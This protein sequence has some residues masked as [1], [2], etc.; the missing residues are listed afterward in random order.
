M[1][2]W[3]PFLLLLSFPV[4]QGF[5]GSL[6]QGLVAHWA[7]DERRGFY[8]TD[9]ISG[10][11]SKINYVFEK[12]R[13]KPSSD[14]RWFDKGVKGGALLFD[15]YSTWIEVEPNDFPQIFGSFSVEVW[16]APKV[17]GYGD[18]GKLSAIISQS[19]EHEKQGFVLGTFRHGS[20]GF[21]LGTGKEWITLIVYDPPLKKFAWNYIVATVDVENHALKL[22]LN[23]KKVKFSKI[24][25]GSKMIQA[26]KKALI[27]RNSDSLTLAGFPLNMFC[28]I[29]DELRIYNRA[30][31][32]E[33]VIRQYEFYTKESCIPKLSWYDFI[34]ENLYA[35]DLHRPTYHAIPPEHWM[36]EP[37]APFYYKGKY[38][39]FY[40]HNPQ[41][42]YWHNIHWGHWVSDDMVHWVHLPYALTPER[43][44][45][46]PDGCWS[47][48]VTFNKDGIPVIFYTAGNDR[49][50]PNQRIAMARPNDPED[51]YLVSWVKHPEPVLVQKPGEGL[52]GEFRDPF[53]WKDDSEEKWYMLVGSG[54][55]TEHAGAALIYTSKDLM[56]WQY[57]GVLYSQ[58]HRA[59][60][61][62]WELPVLLP[63]KDTSGKHRKWI[64]LVSPARGG[65]VEVWYWLGKFDKE[66]LRFVP[67]HTEPRLLDV[68][69]GV[70][71][72][73]SGFVD[74]QSGRTILFTIAQDQRSSYQ[75]YD[76]GWAHN[77]GLP[78][79]LYL[80]D[81]NTVGLKPIDELH[82]LRE[83][84]LLNARNLTIEQANKLIL[85]NQVRGATLEI[86]AEFNLKDN[87]GI[88]VKVMTSKEEY[89]EETLIYYDKKEHS[90]KVDREFSSYDMFAPSF[91]IQGG[92]LELKSEDLILHIYVDHSLIE[93]YANGKISLTTRTYPVDSESNWIRLWSNKKETKV[94]QIQV[95]KLR[96]ATQIA[97]EEK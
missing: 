38:H 72:G 57:G 78:V 93:T 87:E 29:M 5:T 94:K 63:I 30:I 10:E 62:V 24:P 45:L 14:P 15:G 19:N 12:A 7:F 82:S 35:G 91:G 52:W 67:D 73:P 28:G 71:T 79:E 85:D 21:T 74:P 27:G 36:N 61:R 37:H 11:V 68:G 32:E 81:E 70:F 76:A 16:I 43:G 25:H 31:T 96:S 9:V 20:W 49:M 46:D 95:W 69:N 33:E 55:P 41:G 64:L 17:F 77:A 89:G 6:D 1:K 4:A 84:I 75:H 90:L 58:K 65:D 80:I 50:N 42:P 83:N 66:N 13:Y 59:L 22:Y 39:L 54:H 51:P 2:R 92:H 44:G 23:G 88:G 97:K 8:A 18:G 48:S 34:D 56:N 86:I 3:L 47:G 40:Q 26:N 53:V 60:G